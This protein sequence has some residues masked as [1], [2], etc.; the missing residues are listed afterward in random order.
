MPKRD[1]VKRARSNRTFSALNVMTSSRDFRVEQIYFRSN[2]ATPGIAQVLNRLQLSTRIYLFNIKIT[3][4][5]SL[6]HENQT[7][8]LGTLLRAI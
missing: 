6:E 2:Y 7:I 8:A 1:V 3:F 5:V 4:G